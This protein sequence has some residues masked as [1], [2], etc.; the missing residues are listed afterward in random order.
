PV[1]IIQ[2][3]GTAIGSERGTVYNDAFSIT[4]QAVM[5][6]PQLILLPEGILPLYVNDDVTVQKQWGELA[7]Q[8]KGDLLVGG[9]KEGSSTVVQYGPNGTQINCYQKI[10]EV[11]FFENGEGKPF[12]FFPENH[13]SVLITKSGKVGTLICYESMFSSLAQR[14]V[15]QGAQLLFTST[16]DSWFDSSQAKTLHV[17]HGAYRAVETGRTLVQAAING[18]TAVF[19]ASGNMTYNAPEKTKVIVNA[20]V[21]F[22][23]VDT[24]YNRIGDWWLAMGI[25]AVMTV[26]MYLQMKKWRVNRD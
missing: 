12:R 23:T 22:D 13:P 24:L 17:A 25:F 16:N 7:K 1:A 2:P 26:A 5:S 20:T 21:T 15:S 6:K 4:Q 14:S 11:P 3:G 18:M 19:D 9:S 8:A 10:R